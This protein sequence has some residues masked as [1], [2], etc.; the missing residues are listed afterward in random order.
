MVDFVVVERFER[1]LSGS[2]GF[3]ENHS[4][5]RVFESLEEQRDLRSVF[6]GRAVVDAVE[7]DQ[8]V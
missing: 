7:L 6:C 4:N 5:D 2:D 8:R 3:R 1:D